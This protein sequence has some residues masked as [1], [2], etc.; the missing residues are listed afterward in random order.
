MNILRYFVIE[1]SPV[2]NSSYSTGVARTALG[3]NAH[4]QYEI[5]HGYAL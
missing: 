1:Y 3:P 4:T 2:F 5:S